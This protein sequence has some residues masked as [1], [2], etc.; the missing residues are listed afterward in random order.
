[1]DPIEKLEKKNANVT[2]LGDLI[3]YYYDKF[4]E[5]YENDELRNLA[6]TTVIDD[7]LARSTEK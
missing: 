3:S 1:M 2:T 7:L 4:S 6:V 5:I